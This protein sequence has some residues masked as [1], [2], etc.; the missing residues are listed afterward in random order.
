MQAAENYIR[1]NH[2]AEAL[3]VL[4]EIKVHNARWYYLSAMANAGQGNNVLAKEQAQKA[5]SLEPDNMVYRQLL[6][7]MENGGQWYQTRGS[8]YGSPM[9]GGSDWCMRICL[10][11]ALCGCCC[12][13]PI[14]FC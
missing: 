4:S 3:H 13:R 12:G 7:Q 8:M 14:Y 5:V 11:N 1:S 6:S 2:F 10:L 9:A